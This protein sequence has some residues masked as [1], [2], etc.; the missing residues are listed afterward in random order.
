M[1]QVDQNK[2]RDLLEAHTTGLIT[3]EEYEQVRST[4]LET[5]VTTIACPVCTQETRLD[6][7]AP[8]PVDA[9]LLGTS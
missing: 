3:A 5:F 6:G 7:T 8:L 1:A 2:L 4:A 9:G